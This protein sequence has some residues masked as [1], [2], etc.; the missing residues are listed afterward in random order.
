MG[1]V[2]VRL[3]LRGTAAFAA[4]GTL[5]TL[6]YFAVASAGSAIGLRA[7]M[8]SLAAY[9]VSSLLSYSGHRYLT[10]RSTAPVATTAPRFL[11]LTLAQY[12]LALAIPAALTDVAGLSPTVSYLAVCILAP[13]TSLLVMSRYVFRAPVSASLEAVTT[14]DKALEPANA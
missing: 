7:Y 11:Q 13:L 9:A 10:F 14:G 1:D 3:G 6:T 12:A 5:A 4:V 2:A 8:S